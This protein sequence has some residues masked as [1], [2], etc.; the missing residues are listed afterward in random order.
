MFQSWI[1]H[2]AYGIVTNWFRFFIHSDINHF[3]HLALQFSL[4]MEG[5]SLPLE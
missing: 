4:E 2:M 5:E 3:C 1:L